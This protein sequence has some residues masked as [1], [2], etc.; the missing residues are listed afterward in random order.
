MERIQQVI[1]K[2]LVG[3]R[4]GMLEFVHDDVIVIPFQYVS[5]ADT[6]DLTDLCWV[7]G[8]YDRSQLSNL[9][10]L[11]RSIAEP[12]ADHIIRALDKYVTDMDVV[13]AW[14]SVS[15]LNMPNS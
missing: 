10:S 12:C 3:W 7:R 6:V 1:Q 4:G 5:V 15:Q 9:Y 11:N 8:G 13:K 14:D 2:L